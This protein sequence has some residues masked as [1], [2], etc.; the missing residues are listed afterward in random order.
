MD[1]GQ[2]GQVV[3]NIVI[4]AIQ[5]MPEG[6]LLRIGL[7][8]TTVD[9]ATV[10]ELAAGRYLKLTIADHGPGIDPEHLSRIFDPYFT[11]KPN[12][13]GLGLATVYSIIKRHLGR[14]EV[15]SKL[16]EGTTFFIWLPAAQAPP[17]AS[18]AAA[19]PPGRPVGRVLVMVSRS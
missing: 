7:C 9:A 18:T 17:A 3:Q 8:N 12:G 13:S 5:A 19:A 15:Q 11:T 16:G 6:G 4:N 14:I 1:K 2:I 10:P